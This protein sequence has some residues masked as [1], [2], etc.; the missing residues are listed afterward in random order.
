MVTCNKYTVWVHFTFLYYIKIMLCISIKKFISN[1]IQLRAIL[2]LSNLM[3]I[4]IYWE[5]TIITGLW[6]N[7]VVPSNDNPMT[8]PDFRYSNGILSGNRWHALRRF[9]EKKTSSMYM[10]KT[11][12][13]M[14]PQTR[15]CE[16]KQFSLITI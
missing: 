13:E 12:P 8:F 9:R 3:L 6:C 5:F 7:L 1:N 11:L 10:I 16:A 14:S 4:Y 15:R 2:W